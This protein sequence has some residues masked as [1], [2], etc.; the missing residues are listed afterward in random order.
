[1]LK[2]LLSAQY[3]H[4]PCNENLKKLITMKTHKQYKSEIELELN[5][6]NDIA[7]E[8]TI[9]ETDYN[10]VYGGWRLNQKDTK[11]G[12]DKICVLSNPYRLD[13]RSFLYYMHAII[14]SL[15]NVNKLTKPF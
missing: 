9:F 3:T 6:L 1:M 12:R 5:I 13:S 8:G 14:A 2:V 15:Y 7:A 11:T 10:P 4:L